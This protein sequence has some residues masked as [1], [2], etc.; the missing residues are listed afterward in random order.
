MAML[1][2]FLRSFVFRSVSMWKEQM[3]NNLEKR[4]DND[5]NHIPR[6]SNLVLLIIHA[7]INLG[8]ET[9]S[10]TN[11]LSMVKAT[12]I[13]LGILRFGM[14]AWSFM[15]AGMLR[16]ANWTWFGCWGYIGEWTPRP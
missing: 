12:G 16:W 9:Q 7:D 13:L 1:D 8:H 5:Q 4:A 2:L 15:G 3:G 14:E 6:L 10:L 11:D